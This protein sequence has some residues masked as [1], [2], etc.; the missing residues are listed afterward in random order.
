MPFFVWIL[1][2]N[3]K[4]IIILFLFFV[5][6]LLVR[7]CT[8][9]CTYVYEAL[10]LCFALKNSGLLKQIKIKFKMIRSAARQEHTDKLSYYPLFVFFELTA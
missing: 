8:Y 6:I 2:V 7:V 4:I 10:M 9:A 3:Q 5:F 1:N